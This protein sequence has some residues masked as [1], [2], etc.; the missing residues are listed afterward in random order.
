MMNKIL[1]VVTVLVAV[2]LFAGCSNEV[3]DFQKIH[4]LLTYDE[5]AIQHTNDYDVRIKVCSSAVQALQKFIESYPLGDSTNRARNLLSIWEVRHEEAVR[6]K[7][8]LMNRLYS[9]L[10]ERAVQEARNIHPFSRVADDASLD[11][12]EEWRQGSM[13]EVN[14]HYTITLRE[15]AKVKRV[16]KLKVSVSGNLSIDTRKIALDDRVNVVG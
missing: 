16:F 6:E 10:K 14:D 4:Q 3:E 1:L 2:S 9:L 15:E 12:R 8:T 5:Q 11:R 13:I 7:T